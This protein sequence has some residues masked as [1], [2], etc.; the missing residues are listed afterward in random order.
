MNVIE[1][2]D[3]PSYGNGGGGY[4]PK[5]IEYQKATLK[6]KTMK[7]KYLDN[8]IQLLN[9]IKRNNEISDYGQ[10]KLNEFIAIK[11]QLTLT[12]VKRSVSYGHLLHYIEIQDSDIATIEALHDL[13]LDTHGYWVDFI[14]LKRARELTAKMYKALY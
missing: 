6:N 5:R 11:E 12:D 10:E 14:A 9:S 3:D 13:L 7:T 8:E 4:A 2:W 1:R